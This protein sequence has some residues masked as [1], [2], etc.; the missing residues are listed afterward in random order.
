[1]PIAVYD[2][3]QAALR[4]V[5]ST[6]QARGEDAI[7]ALSLQSQDDDGQTRTL[8]EGASL[9]KRASLANPSI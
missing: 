1:L 8:A 2:T 5:W 9:V 3:E 7:S 6:V 4:D